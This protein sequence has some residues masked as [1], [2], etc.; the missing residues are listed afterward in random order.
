MAGATWSKRRA[1]QHWLLVWWEKSINS[2]LLLAGTW[3]KYRFLPESEGCSAEFLA[4]ARCARACARDDGCT[5]RRWGSGTA[6]SYALTHQDWGWRLIWKL[7]DVTGTGLSHAPE[8][9]TRFV[10]Q[11]NSVAKLFRK[12]ASGVCW[13]T[14]VN[15]PW[16][17][18]AG[19]K[20][21]QVQITLL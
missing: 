4:Q 2:L 19:C 21:G 17:A 3:S 20:T 16:A 5:S 10:V 18:W 14:C 8:L 12:T 7:H 9:W 13:R 11:P 6:F 15:Q 1:L